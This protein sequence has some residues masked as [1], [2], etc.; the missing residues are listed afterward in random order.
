MA[1]DTLTHFNIFMYFDIIY[2]LFY[3][4]PQVFLFLFFFCKPNTIFFFPTGWKL[5][6]AVTW[7][8]CS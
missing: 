4:G 3:N 5:L 1:S 7:R 8:W 2:L 6:L